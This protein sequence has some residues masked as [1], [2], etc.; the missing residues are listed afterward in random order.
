ML[1]LMSKRLKKSQKK[2][3]NEPETRAKE[4]NY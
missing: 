4:I 3:P 2:E 1:K